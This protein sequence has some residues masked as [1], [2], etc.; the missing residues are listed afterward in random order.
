M[1]EPPEHGLD[2]GVSFVRLAKQLTSADARRENDMPVG[3]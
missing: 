1:I 3:A 2:G